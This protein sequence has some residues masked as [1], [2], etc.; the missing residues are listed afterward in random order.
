M[1]KYSCHNGLCTQSTTLQSSD[2]LERDPKRFPESGP[3]VNIKNNNQEWPYRVTQAKN[4]DVAPG[5]PYTTP[6]KKSRMSEFFA[7]SHPL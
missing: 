5:A 2:L 4:A 3:N 1:I 7:F 6:S